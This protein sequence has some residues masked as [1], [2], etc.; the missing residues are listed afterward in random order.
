MGFKKK[1]DLLLF[2]CTTKQNHAENFRDIFDIKY[3]AKMH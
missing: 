2:G 3:H 1:V